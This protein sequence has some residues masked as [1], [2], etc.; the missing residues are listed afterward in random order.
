M[1]KSDATQLLGGSHSAAAE[2]IGITPQ[3]YGQWPEILP[4][5]LED[6]VVAAIARRCLPADAFQVKSAE[7]VE[8]ETQNV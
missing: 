7:L 5:R 4:K 2:A 8:Q 3:A 1:K 6:R